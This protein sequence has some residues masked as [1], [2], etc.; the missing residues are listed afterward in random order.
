MN[1]A[2]ALQDLGAARDHLP[3]EALR[4]LR[5]N[6]DVAGPAASLVL[7]RCARDPESAADHDM[8]AGYFLLH[9]MAEK[10]E[11]SAAALLLRLAKSPEGLTAILGD[12][13]DFTLTPMFISLLG[14][15][16]RALQEIVEN[17][18]ADWEVKACALTA[19]AY[20]AA[21][22]MTD[23][24][25]LEFWMIGLPV[26]WEKAEVDESC[27]DGFAHAVALLGSEDL[28]PLARAAFD[29]GLIHEVLLTR[30]EF[31]EVHAL[32]REEANPLATFEREGLA[33]F[34]DAIT[35]LAVV[36]AAIQMAAEESPEDYDDG[37]PDEDEATPQTIVN[38]YRDTGRNDPCPCGSGMKFKKCHGAG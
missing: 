20:A 25:A 24:A 6:W 2:T 26:L 8:I 5:D 32:A 7:A 37:L 38:P 18:S 28:A 36:E 21:S 17:A 23:R 33:P 15:D 31:E 3:E 4:W 1:L 12:A 16:A 22:G 35:S 30:A 14:K 19:L 27:F 11:P 34:A 13:I 29:A 10:G 9:L